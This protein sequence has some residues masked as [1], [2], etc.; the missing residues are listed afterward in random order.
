MS[1]GKAEISVIPQGI[2]QLKNKMAN[3][4]KRA[5]GRL[6]IVPL[7]AH[8]PQ[9]FPL[10]L[11]ALGFPPRSPGFVLQPLAVEMLQGLPSELLGISLCSICPAGSSLLHVCSPLVCF[12][13]GLFLLG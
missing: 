6:P 1:L 4:K 13:Q 11:F 5:Q 2:N 8:S 9:S 7:L 10:P 12:F 3:N